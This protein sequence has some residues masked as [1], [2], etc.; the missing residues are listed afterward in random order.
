MTTTKESGGSLSKDISAA[1][2]GEKKSK[3]ETCH[4]SVCVGGA[5]P[6]SCVCPVTPKK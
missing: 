3:L 4:P 2:E 6:K 5:T 1:K